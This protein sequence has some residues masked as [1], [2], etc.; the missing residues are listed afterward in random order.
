MKTNIF[1]PFKI[2]L[3][4]FLIMIFGIS[5]NAQ[6]DK[7]LGR[8]PKTSEQEIKNKPAITFPTA[9]SV[10]DGPFVIIGKAEP[11]TYIT[12]RVTPI[13]NFPANPS[14]KPTLRISGKEYEPQELSIKADE[15]GIWQSPAIS[16]LFDPK[17]INTKIFAFVAQK[18]GSKYYESK[19]IEYKTSRVLFMEK[20]PMKIPG[21]KK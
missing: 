17:A 21:K 6:S 12:L 20:V 5:A 4:L 18:S 14:G 19:N 9:G 3:S 13:Y 16:V 2:V 8:K 15:K 7:R 1:N 10:I 11:N